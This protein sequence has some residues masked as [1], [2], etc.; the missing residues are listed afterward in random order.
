VG[1][2]GEIRRHQAGLIQEI[3]TMSQNER[4]IAIEEHFVSPMMAREFSGHHKLSSF[5]HSTRR[6]E[7]LGI[8]RIREMDEAGIDVQV[9]SHLQ[10]GPQVFEPDLSVA[11]A[12]QANNIL[13]DG[14][15]VHPERFAGFAA[16]PTPNPEAAA[17][18]L[19]RTVSEF[20]FK[21]AM[22]TG[23]SNGSFLD[24]RKFWPIFERAAKLDVPIYLHPAIP[25]E[26]V[27][28]TYYDGYRN[29]E[30]PIL[31]GAVWG[32]TV[33]TATHALRLILSGVF[34]EYP[35]LKIILGHLGETLPFLLWRLEWTYNNLTKKSGIAECFRRHFY[36]TTSG[37]FSQPALLCTMMELG[38]NRILFAV[39]WPF[40]SN[41]EGVAF[42]RAASLKPEEKSRIFAGNAAGLLRM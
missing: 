18:E 1:K 5:M 28:K 16:L 3:S 26:T 38:G 41:V 15:Q 23:L 34:Q 11:L 12:R 29:D 37:N 10:P 30:Y 36:V 9:I 2:G 24:D 25:S 7:D 4:I 6:L 31:M 14:I 17:D 39:D 19:E 33:E 42:I 22:I 40:N 8:A 35:Q 21:G 13:H 20:A 27:V 32:F